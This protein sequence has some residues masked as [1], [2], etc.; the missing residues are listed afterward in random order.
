M[1]RDDVLELRQQTRAQGLWTLADTV[2]ALGLPQ[3]ARSIATSALNACNS[4][5]H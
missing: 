4:T 5:E 1:T 2:R 3:P